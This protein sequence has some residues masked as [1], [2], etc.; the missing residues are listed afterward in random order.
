MGFLNQFFCYLSNTFFLYTQIIM[1]FKIQLEEK[2]FE[3][4]NRITRLSGGDINDAFKIET[5][6]NIYALKVNRRDSYPKMFTKE[7][8]GLELIAQTGA[9]VPKVILTF[10]NSNYQF[11]LLEFITESSADN[12]FWKNF[13]KDL[14]KVHQCFGNIF[15]LDYNNYIG[16]LNQNNT[17]KSLWNSFFIENRLMPLVK[18]AYD[19]NLLKTKHLRSFENFYQRVNEIIPLEKPSLVHGDLWGGNIMKSK[20]NTP[21][22]IDPAIYY[23]H[24][25]IDISMTQMFGGFDNSYL[26]HYDNI[27]PLEKDWKN[28][29]QIHNLYPNLVHLNLFG[30]GYLSSIER[31]I[32]VF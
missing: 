19:N 25:E 8:M 4:I 7:K 11:L 6:N 24:R 1:H 17:Q 31:V 18:S 20:N 15:G 21:I 10:S 16:S 13:A 9:K 2:L 14:V 12:I 26:T 32:K 23:G 27:F 3:K 5:S 22:F 29:I 28:R 30:L